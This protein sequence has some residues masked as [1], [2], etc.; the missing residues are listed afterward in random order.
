VTQPSYRFDDPQFYLHDADA[1]FAR[2]RR[3]DPVHWHAD[4]GFWALTR[5][6]DVLAV[7]RDPQ[8]FKSGSGVLLQDRS[9]EVMAA[10][11]LL[12]LDPPRHSRYRK[13]V[14]TQFTPRAVTALE[15]RVRTL[16]REVLDAADPRAEIDLVDAVTAPVP[17]LVIAEL[18]GV[19]AEDHDRFRTW[20]DRIIDAAT[21]MSPES[22]GP[23]MELFG[24]FAEHLGVRR[25]EP[26][27][28]V[29][30]RLVVAEVDGERLS[31]EELL[32]FCMTLLVAGNETTRNLLS[33]G[34]V[35]LA[36]H[37]EQRAALAADARMIPTAVEEML[38][39]VS[40]IILFARTATV[41]TEIG[42][43]PVA[44][45]DYVV[46]FYAAANRDEHV[47]GPTAGEFDVMRDPNPH[48]AFGF[49]EHFCLGAGLARLEARVVLEELLTRWPSYQLL[50]APDRVPSTLL[51]GIAKL[52]GV[53]GPVG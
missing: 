4:G 17:M 31:D 51:R 2:L 20:S 26:R 39:W 42:G 12:Y 15:D 11:S 35:A 30:S 46:M 41:D 27:D 1:A 49:G 24:Y 13:I 45:G 48:L 23:A 16:T 5:H 19:P 10:D 9:R 40:P 38:R 14:S 50:G 8:T 32:G 37:P 29:L 33:G 18:L 44:E 21:E 47:F 3:D 43:T 34:L 25:Q 6:A 28:D 52:P 53:L 7:S 22:L 36:E